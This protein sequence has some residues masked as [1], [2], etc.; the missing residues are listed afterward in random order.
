MHILVVFVHPSPKCFN[1]EILATV[2]DEVAAK[3]HVCVV[4]DLNAEKFNPV[5]SEA[6]FESFNRGTA[7][8]DVKKMQD[9]V[10]AADIVV[11][12]HPVWWYGLPA[13]L[14]GWIDRVFSYGF[15]YGHDSR[16]VK[17]LLFG[18]KAIVINTAGAAEGSAYND[19]GFK[20]AM[21]RLTDQGIYN[22]VGLEVI[23]RRMFFEVPAASDAERRDMLAVLKRDLQRVL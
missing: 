10:Q 11:F 23:L 1:R 5:L 8:K 3:G 2:R 15:A 20:D 13:I 12:I 6:D 4:R 9:A 14:K 18:K 17:P 21:V 7:P 22:F 19:N 16:G